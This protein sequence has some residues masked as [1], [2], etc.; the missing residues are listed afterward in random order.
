MHSPHVN[1]VP[2]P[3]TNIRC[4]LTAKKR[5]STT[6]YWTEQ[7]NTDSQQA[8]NQDAP[9]LTLNHDVRP[10]AKYCSAASAQQDHSICRSL[11]YCGAAT[12]AAAAGATAVAGAAGVAV[13][14]AGAAAATAG[15]AVAAGT[16]A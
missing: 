8:P 15:A 7:A 16:G 5:Q 12:G 4:P 6:Q 11:A 10:S 9:I 2:S 13:V 3:S 14:T 1:A